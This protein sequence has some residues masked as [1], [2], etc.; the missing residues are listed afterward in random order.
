MAQALS[1]HLGINCTCRASVPIP[2][3]IGF[4]RRSDQLVQLLMLWNQRQRQ[5]QDLAELDDHFLRDVGISREAAERE[6]ARPFW[7]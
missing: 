4:R 7:T 5:R 2:F 3:D 6:A 1:H